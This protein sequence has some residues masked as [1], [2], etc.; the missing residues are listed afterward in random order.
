[1]NNIYPKCFICGQAP[2]NGLYDGVRLNH[3][4]ICSRCE[5]HIVGTNSGTAA[6][7]ENICYIKAI[8]YR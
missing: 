4:F 3:K 7:L 5:E 1:M 8:L 6:Y 2:G